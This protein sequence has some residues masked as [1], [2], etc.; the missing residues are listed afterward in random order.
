MVHVWLPS[1]G[2]VIFFL[3]FVRLENKKQI[4]LVSY[5]IKEI[6]HGLCMTGINNSIF[7]SHDSYFCNGVGVLDAYHNKTFEIK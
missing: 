4:S 7:S 3:V 1:T 6:I 5:I 2:G